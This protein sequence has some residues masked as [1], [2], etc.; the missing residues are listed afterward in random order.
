MPAPV[1]V[2]VP[3]TGRGESPVAIYREYGPP[4][5]GAGH[6]IEFLFVVPVTRLEQVAEL[7]RLREAGEPVRVLRVAQPT[8]SGMLVRVGASEARFETLL[9]LPTIRRITGESVP[10]LIAMLGS[11][12]AVFASR[13]EIAANFFN[14]TQ[15]R[16]YNAFAR[17][18]TR[19]RFE[20]L[21][22]GVGVMRRDALREVP[23]YGEFLRFLPLLLQR[24]GFT[25]V[26]APADQHTADAGLRLHRPA[27][28]VQAFVDLLGFYFLSRFTERPL[29][30]F[31]FIGTVAAIA[32]LVV[33]GVLLVQ[34]LQGQG[35]ANRPALLLGTLL[36]ALGVQSIAVGLVAE[37]IVHVSAPTRRPYR[38]A[39]DTDPTRGPST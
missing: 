18:A 8:G 16:W 10:G 12:D 9:L 7:E 39:R 17:F 27:S 6:E 36:L 30:F 13:R 3:V 15:R 21:G 31:G 28:Y 2:I 4:L 35:I 11:H 24:E 38:L 1:S 29:R 20:D 34:R 14:R 32:G 5:L 23:M 25:V 26:S 22:C 37:I 19:G 33:L